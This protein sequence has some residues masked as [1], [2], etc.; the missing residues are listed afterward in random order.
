MRL[1]G[2]L[3]FMVV[4]IGCVHTY[5]I[6]TPP[7]LIPKLNKISQFRNDGAEFP[8]IIAPPIECITEEV[9]ELALILHRSN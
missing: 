1:L 4:M 2:L 8:T 6:K 7:S 5:E 9:F 3:S